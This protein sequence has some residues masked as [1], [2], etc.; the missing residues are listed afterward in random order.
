ML[1]IMFSGLF[2]SFLAS[3]GFGILFNIK[4]K[5]L[6]LAGIGGA[7]YKL[8]LFLGGSEMIAMFSGSVVFSLYSEILARVCKTPVTTFIICA[9]IPLVPGGG[10]YRTMQQAIAGNIDKALAIGLNTISIAGV[11]VLG[12]LLVSTLMRAFYH[13][14]KERKARV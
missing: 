8:V 6:I 3:L 13:M 5:N 14:Q 10:M 11:L 2:S 7:V 9:L 1:Q 4:G 12:I